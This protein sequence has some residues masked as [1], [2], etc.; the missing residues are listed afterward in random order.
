MNSLQLDAK[1]YIT[2]YGTLDLN[3]FQSDLDQKMASITRELKINKN[4]I[5]IEI[6]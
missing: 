5:D 2:N 6:I 1:N 3:H 4:Y